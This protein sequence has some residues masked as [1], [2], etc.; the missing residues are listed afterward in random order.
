MH[1]RLVSA[2]A[3]N[4][5]GD[6]VS[7]RLQ[8]SPAF[9]KPDCKITVG[10]PVPRHSRYMDRPSTSSVMS[11]LVVAVEAVVLGP[12]VAVEESPSPDDEQAATKRAN[13]ALKSA[14]PGRRR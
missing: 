13:A 6:V 14:M 2:T 9:P 4:T 11:M 1:T 3:G 7:L 10:L 5:A 12:V 8:M